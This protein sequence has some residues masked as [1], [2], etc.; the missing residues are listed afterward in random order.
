MIDLARL[1]EWLVL[2]ERMVQFSDGIFGYCPWTE[3]GLTSD[4][5]E[6]SATMPLEA[7]RHGVGYASGRRG[8]GPFAGMTGTPADLE[9]EA[10]LI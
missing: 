6:P 9:S 2:P 8:E 3:Q 5:L 7:S 10:V 4:G 1:G